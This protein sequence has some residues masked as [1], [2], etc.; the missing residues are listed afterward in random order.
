MLNIL[1]FYV[2]RNFD[3]MESILCKLVK[4]N[5]DQFLHVPARLVWHSIEVPHN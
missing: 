1:L 5:F 4:S 2:R 3:V